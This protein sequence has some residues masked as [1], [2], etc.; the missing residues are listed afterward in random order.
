M[1]DRHRERPADKL[2]LQATALQMA[3]NNEKAISILEQALEMEP[4]YHPLKLDLAKNLI[5]LQR[6]EEAKQLLKE[7]PL[8]VQ[9]DKEVSELMAHFMFSSVAANAPSKETL[10]MTLA[11]TPEDLMARYQLSACQVLEDDYEAALENLLELMRRNRKF[12]E[13]AGRKGI[14]AVFTL[15][16]N[17]GPV[18]SR[19]RGKMAALLY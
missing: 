9:A 10:K 1:I 12:E 13:D 7:L 5:D 14:L 11:N 6:F 16:G 15:L 8:N 19:Y 4:N 2:R 18:V 17:Q 3:G